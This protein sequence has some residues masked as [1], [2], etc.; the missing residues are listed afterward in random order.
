[1]ILVLPPSGGSERRPMAFR[2]KAEAT[3]R[4]TRSWKPEAGS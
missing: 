2:L 3:E 4:Q 1:M